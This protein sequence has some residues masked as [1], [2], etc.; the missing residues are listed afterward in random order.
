MHHEVDSRYAW[1]RLGINLA[2]MTIGASGMY[3]V[4]VVLPSVQAEFG[5]AR[6][7]ASLPYTLTMIGFGLGGIMMGRLA[8]RFGILVPS[9]IG[10]VALSAGFVAAAFAPSLL[11]FAIVQGVVI[12]FLGSSSTFPPL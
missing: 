9:V 3:V 12:G 4:V 8:D 11:V 6:G 10:A 5:V 7:E 1:F 2:L